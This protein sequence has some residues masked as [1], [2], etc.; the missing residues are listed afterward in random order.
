MSDLWRDLLYALRTLAR[1]RVFV[2]FVVLTLALAIGANTTVFT[3]INTLLL[4]PLPVPKS[5]ELVSVN[6]A[7]TGARASVPLQLSYA[8]F[9]D[10][11]SRATV[12]RSLAAYSSPHPVTWQAENSSQGL[13]LE[14]VT[15]NYFPTLGLTSAR[16]RFFLPEEDRAPG[17][18]PVA[19]MS[20]GTWKLR[21]GADPGIIGR[22]LR[23][24]NLVLTIVGVAPEHFI[25]V[26]AIFGPD[27][28]VPMAMAEQLFPTEMATQLVQPD[29]SAV[30]FSHSARQIS[31]VYL[32]DPRWI[33]SA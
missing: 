8:D 13:F 29:F 30:A 28:W 26:N 15:G 9:K 18:H 10:I 2:V 25:G 22:T 27:L 33:R 6:C 5:S 4:N 31:R 14:L 17:A 20:Y 16:G 21:F 12:F 19:V 3:V 11:Q 32:A 23:L 24:N 7:N 1:A